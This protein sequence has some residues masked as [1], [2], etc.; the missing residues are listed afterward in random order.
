[1]KNGGQIIGILACCALAASGALADE[2]TRDAPAK[3]VAKPAKSRQSAPPKR[4]K[5]E[6]KN[7]PPAMLPYVAPDPKSLGLGCASGED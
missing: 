4:V 2:R 7:V 1:M 5:T 6:T 3:P